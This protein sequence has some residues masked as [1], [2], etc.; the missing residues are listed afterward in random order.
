[1]VRQYE[2]EKTEDAQIL[3]L[4]GVGKYGATLT[5]DGAAMRRHPLLNV[6]LFC[7]SFSEMM[8]V[9][10][11]DASQDHEDE[12]TAA[13]DKTESREAYIFNEAIY[14]GITAAGNAQSR[15]VIKKTSAGDSGDS[16]GE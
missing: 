3:G 10:V 16:G 1:L 5:T 11:F 12:I 9:A 13:E 2:A 4:P 14:V 15:P 8:L 7:V 6:V